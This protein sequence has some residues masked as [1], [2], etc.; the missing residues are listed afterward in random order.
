MTPPR[1]GARA[2]CSSSAACST[3]K[4]KP[5]PNASVMVYAGSSSRGVATGIG[6][7]E[8]RRRSARRAAT[9]RAGSG[10]TRRAPRRR[11]IDHSVPSRW[12]PATV[13][14]GSSSTPTPIS[15]PPNHAPPRTGDPGPAVRP[16]GRPSAASRSRSGHRPRPP[17]DPATPASRSLEG[18]LFSVDQPNDLPGLAQA[19]DHRR[20]RPLHPARRRPGPSGG[21]HCP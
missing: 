17:G 9:A 13:P 4:G 14:A 16:A 3:R 7:R 2:G 8:R 5:V 15:L 6:D 1:A 18:P 19:G 12:R 11:D 21:P 10:S 20:R